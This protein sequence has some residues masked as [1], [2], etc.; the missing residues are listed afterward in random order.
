MSLV[1]CRQL[2]LTSIDSSQR[3]RQNIIVSSNQSR[4]PN[5][6]FGRL[7][8]Q[9]DLPWFSERQISEDYTNFSLK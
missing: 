3:D 1:L 6:L 7:I 4:G 8:V 5:Q 9:V 2:I